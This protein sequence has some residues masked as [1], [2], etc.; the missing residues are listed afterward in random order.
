MYVPRNKQI[1]L[2][3]A[4]VIAKRRAGRPIA[5]RHAGL[6]GHIGKRA[7]VIVAVQPVLAKVRNKNVRPAIVV[8]VANRD[9]KPQRSF[10]TP[11]SPPHQ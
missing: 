5:Q 7:V 11:L 6:F 3:I 10:V 9:S 8:V 2:S 1:Q 4:V